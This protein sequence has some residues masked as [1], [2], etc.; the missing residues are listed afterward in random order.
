MVTGSV[1][2]MN[3]NCKIAQNDAILVE[4]LLTSRTVKEAAENAGV[5]LRT[6]YYRLADPDFQELYQGLKK[7]QIENISTQINRL[8]QLALV[9]IEE[10]LTSPQTS[11]KDRLAAA[12]IVLGA[13]NHG[14]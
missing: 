10:I 8:S 2:L 5:S 3:E 4:S 13:R 6:V 7:Q 1:I 11:T 12:R 14:E 9:E